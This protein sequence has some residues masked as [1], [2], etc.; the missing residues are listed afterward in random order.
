MMG[1]VRL[2]C[3]P[4]RPG[5][6]G[7]TAVGG[8]QTETGEVWTY[9]RPVH[10]PRRDPTAARVVQAYRLH[11]DTIARIDAEAKRT[12]EGAGQV[13]DRLSAGL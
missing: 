7:W 12:G 13:L 2:A 8:E 3:W 4:S 5:L 6:V 10:R 1:A 9:R 11:P